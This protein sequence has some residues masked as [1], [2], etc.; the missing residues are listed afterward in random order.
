MSLIG[1]VFISPG[2]IASVSA[3]NRATGGI[4]KQVVVQLDI[5]IL[6]SFIDIACRY[7]NGFCEMISCLEFER[8]ISY[9]H[10]SW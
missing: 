9:S 7:D 4:D 8:H 10:P 5:I 1:L 3:R 6:K 2:Q